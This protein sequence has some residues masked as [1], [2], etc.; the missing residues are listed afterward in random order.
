MVKQYTPEELTL[1]LIHIYAYSYL[2]GSK[3]EE[4][5]VFHLHDKAF[6]LKS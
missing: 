5:T 6:V 1:S 2:I 4:K 3:S